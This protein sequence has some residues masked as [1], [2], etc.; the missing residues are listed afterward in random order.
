[1]N[2]N[3]QQHAFLEALFDA[4]K[5]DDLRLNDWERSF[6]KDNSQRFA[7]YGRGV[8]LSEKQVSLLEKIASQYE[9]E[10]DQF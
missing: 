9:L 5:Q 7:K 8:Y 2:I 1:M 10:M 4:Y 6:M 3:D